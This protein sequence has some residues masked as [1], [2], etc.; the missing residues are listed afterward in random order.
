MGVA[1]DTFLNDVLPFICHTA[2]SEIDLVR[3]SRG[4][5]VVCQADEGKV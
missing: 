4:N 5:M 3:H 1:W 2:A